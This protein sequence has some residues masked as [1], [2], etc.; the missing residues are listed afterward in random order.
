MLPLLLVLSALQLALQVAALVDLLRRPHVTLGDRKWLWGA[1]IVF[2]QL[3]GS[4]LYFAL[5]RVKYS[6]DE[7]PSPLVDRAA[8]EDRAKRIADKL[9]GGREEHR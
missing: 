4:I 8:A 3:I 1:I 6:P 9:Y 2:G 7:R 5:G